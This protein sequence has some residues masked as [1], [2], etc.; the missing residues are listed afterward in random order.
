MSKTTHFITR[1]SCFLIKLNLKKT[2]FEF[3]M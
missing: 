3:E 2:S 1:E